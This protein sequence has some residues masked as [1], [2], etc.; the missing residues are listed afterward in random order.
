MWCYIASFSASSVVSLAC[1]FCLSACLMPRIG[2]SLLCNESLI[3][4]SDFWSVRFNS[5][6]FI[7][8]ILNIHIR[9]CAYG[10]GCVCVWYASALSSRL[11]LRQVFYTHWGSV[12]NRR[13]ARQPDHACEYSSN[14]DARFFSDILTQNTKLLIIATMHLRSLHMLRLGKNV[15]IL[16][17]VYLF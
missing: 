12:C 9:K 1:S 2:G 17:Y 11:R 8:V 14:R 7:N 4:P 15:L 13:P 6:S 3:M 16:V 10:C 5:T